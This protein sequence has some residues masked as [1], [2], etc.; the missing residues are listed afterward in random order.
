MFWQ[1]Q[2]SHTSGK[3]R[4]LKS[5]VEAAPQEW[6][7][8]RRYGPS[9]S[10]LINIRVENGSYTAIMTAYT[11]STYTTPL[12]DSDILTVEDIIYLSVRVPDLDVNTF[13]LKVVNIYVSPTNSND[14]KYYLLRDGCPGSDV[15]ADQITVESNGVGLE[16]RFPMKVFQISNSNTVYLYADLALC[17]T[18]CSTICSQQSRS[19]IIQPVAGNTRNFLNAVAAPVSCE[20]DSCADDEY[21][22][23]STTTCQCDPTLY[24]FTR[25]VAPFVNFTCT[26]AK[27]NIQV[28]KCWLETNGYNTSNIRLNS[29]NSECWAGREVVDGTSEMTIHRPLISSDCNTE[30]VLNETHVIYTNRLFIFAK[31]DPIRITNDYDLYISCSYPLFMTASLDVTLH[32]VLGTTEINGPTANASY[33]AEIKAFKDSTYTAPLSEIDTLDVEDTVYISVGVPGLDVNPFQLKVVTIYASPD[34]ASFIKYY[35]LQ[36]GCPSSDV[37]ADELTVDSNGVGI[38]SRFPM[39]IFQI[40]D[41]NIMY[42]YAELILCTNDCTTTCGNTGSFLD[43]VAA[44]VSCVSEICADDEHCNSAGTACQCNT[45]FYAFIRGSL[46]SPNITC[47]G[48]TFNIQVSKCWLE[49]HGYDTSDMRLNS[50]NTECYTEREIVDGTSEMT[51][52]RPLISSDCNTEA[53]VNETHVTYTNQLY[54]FAQTDPIRI[55]NDAAM[56]VSCSYPLYMAVSLDAVLHPII[57]STVINGLTADGSYSVYMTAYKDNQFMTRLSDSDTLYE[58]DTIYIVVFMP[59]LYGNTFHLKVV[60]IYA[61]PDNSS[62]QKYYLLQKGCPSSDVSADELTVGINGVSSEAWFAMKVFQITN[63]NTIYLYADLALCATDC[64]STCS[65]QSVANITQPI[66]GNARTLMDAAYY[67]YYNAGNST[68]MAAPVS[69]GSDSCADDEHCNNVINTCQCNTTFYT[70]TPGATPFVN[71]TCTGAKFNIQVSKCWLEVN[72]YN[73]SDIRLNSTNSECWAVREVVD[74][75]SEMTLH[76]PLT[77]SDCNTVPVMNETH[78]TYTNQLYIFAKTDPLQITNDVVMNVSCSF[79]LHTSVTLHPTLGPIANA[80]YSVYMRAYKDNRFVTPLSNSYPLYVQ[81]TVYISVVVPDLDVNTFNFKVVNIYASPTNS[82]SN[83]Y[84]LLKNGCP[85]KDVSTDDLT[86]ESNGVGAESRFAMKVFQNT[87]S[88]TAY[89]YAEVALCTNNCS[90]TCSSQSVSNVSQPIVGNASIY[91]DAVVA[92]VSCGSDSC[93]EDEYCN[94]RTACQCNT[95][96]YPF[97]RGSLPSP[98]LICTGE[99]FN[100]QVSKCWLEAQGYR[101]SDIRLNSANSECWAGREVVDGISEMTLHR[102]LITSDCNTEAVVNATHVTYTN[103]LYIFAKMFPIQVVND[104][105]MNIS[106]TYPL[107]LNVSLNVTVHTIVG[108]AEINSPTANVSYSIYIIDYPDEFVT[109]LSH[110]DPLNVEDSIPI[111]V[112]MPDLVANSLNLK[113][114]NIY[115]SSDKSSSTQYNLL[116]DGCP[117]T[118]ISADQLRVE[119]NGVGNEARFATKVFQITNSKTARLSAKFELCVGDCNSICS[120]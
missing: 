97:I 42:L 76:R 39:K 19:L 16:S 50:T 83:K 17:T 57:W 30:A 14:Q 35:L 29:A 80:S 22:D 74:G 66:A 21:C 31:S 68:S 45:T 2:E 60:N 46:P 84:Y 61:S 44:P 110:S 65:S 88:Y 26:G 107:P 23:N 71:F 9:E 52:R 34:N 63:S 1:T 12:S 96:L 104:F 90:S 7:K 103:L 13:K 20:S 5:P 32:P 106:C 92:P 15:P 102:P 59:A 49:V 75:T 33:A 112:Q 98:N 72:S 6:R 79:P 37:S 8:G 54:I 93:A 116:Q 36:N 70:F 53:V 48:E 115:V 99:K 47:T 64:N 94:D 25:G 56:N 51:I 82:G 73:T 40:T 119:S 118:N 89:L 38:E 113:V 67:D 87:N 77:S 27:F 11:D 120:P 105:A 3:C 62:D 58:G 109:T 117:A 81:D 28:S 91:L 55:T 100:I 24:K 69:C 10:G 86:V 114:A 41:S 78:V 43:A 111:A 101:T 18:D 85:S 95:T 108:H 4:I